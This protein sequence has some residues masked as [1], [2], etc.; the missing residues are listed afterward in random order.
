MYIYFNYGSQVIQEYVERM[1]EV[2]DRTN[3]IILA[4][5]GVTNHYALQFEQSQ[6][7][8][9]INEYRVS[10]DEASESITLPAH[11]DGSAISI[12]HQDEVGG[13]Q[14]LSKVGNWVDVK[15]MP[16]SFIV[17]IGDLLQ[18][19]SNKR[20]HSVKHRVIVKG[21]QSRLS[22]TFFKLLPNEIEIEAPPELV[23]NAHPR[24]YKAFRY[25]EY[26]NF[27]KKTRG[28][29]DSPLESY[30]VVQQ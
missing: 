26:A 27:V 6:F 18:A 9:R 17:L 4:T 30:A 2:S 23:D 7:M 28:Q 10:C 5:L 13:L 19:W 1:K 14:V 8:L 21:Q 3:E 25:S 12:L 11:T 29:L 16:N 22:L 24:C 15:P 20:I